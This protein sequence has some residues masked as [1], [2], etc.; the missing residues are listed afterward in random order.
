MNYWAN[1]DAFACEH[2][3]G[4][5]KLEYAAIH[6]FASALSNRPKLFGPD[7]VDGENQYDIVEM[8]ANKAWEHARNLEL[9]F[10]KNEYEEEKK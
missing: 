10:Y 2:S 4:L 5:S 1:K 6:I 7:D 9:S 3:T 8:I